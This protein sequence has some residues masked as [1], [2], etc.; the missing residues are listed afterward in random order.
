LG[1]SLQDNRHFLE[2]WPR[3]NGGARRGDEKMVLEREY[4]ELCDSSILN[5]KRG[6]KGIRI[7]LTMNGEK[8]DASNPVTRKTQDSKKWGRKLKKMCRVERRSRTL[9]WNLLET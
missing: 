6:K 4:G 8:K 2:S 9:A 3:K 1:T 7:R 5:Y